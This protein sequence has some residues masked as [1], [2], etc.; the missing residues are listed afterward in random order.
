MHQCLQ[1]VL[2]FAY[3]E[4]CIGT[5]YLIKLRHF[6]YM[7]FEFHV[8]VYTSSLQK[9][10][11]ILGGCYEVRWGTGFDWTGV[12]PNPWRDNPHQTLTK[13]QKQTQPQALFT[14]RVFYGMRRV[15]MGKDLVN[16]QSLKIQIYFL[17]NTLACTRVFV[18]VK[19]EMVGGSYLGIIASDS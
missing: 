18:L 12:A 4:Y 1:F 3:S 8:D 2:M 5:C 19:N 17:Y 6:R 16:T 13:Y 10:I 7:L 9:L 15:G 11:P 14:I